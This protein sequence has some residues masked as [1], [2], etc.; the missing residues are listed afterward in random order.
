MNG[1]DFDPRAFRD[2]LGM[3]ATGIAVVT[4]RGPSGDPVGLT[5]N[6]FS[7][8]SLDPPLVLWCL[9]L[10]S[11]TLAAFERCTH[12][13]I[14]VLAVEQDG[15]SQHFA[16]SA[17]DRFAGIE[18]TG[19]LGG[20]PLIPGCCAAF[21]CRNEVRHPGGDHLIFVGQ[22]ERFARHEREGLLYFRGGY[23]RLA[24]G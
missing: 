20:A 4:A 17:P 7:S 3:F 14:N 21:E 10:Y 15:L 18:W 12:Y 24:P 6:S 22:V 8:V 1:R 13:A 5:V 16:S 11:P 9:S 23:R 2:A 19:G